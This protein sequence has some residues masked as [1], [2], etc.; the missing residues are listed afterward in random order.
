MPLKIVTSDPGGRGGTLAD[1]LAR[2]PAGLPLADALTLA[3]QI[4]AALEDRHRRGILHA[5]LQP[6]AI[7]VS[8]GGVTLLDVAGG[9]AAVDGAP[10]AYA[11]PEQVR[12][13]TPDR[14]TD[15]W[16]FGC[17][18]FEML[19]G[20]P[21]FGSD[22]RTAALAAIVERHPDWS[23]LP[24]NAPTRI[25]HLLQHCL[26]K[27]PNQRLHDIADARIEIDATRR[28]DTDALER[29]IGPRRRLA[30]PVAWIAIGL[31][32]AA[33][34]GLLWNWRRATQP[35]T[36]T[37]AASGRPLRA[38]LEL[39]PGT[40][41]AI[42]RG[43][44]LALSPDGSRLVYVA[45]SHGTVQLHLRLLD[46]GESTP[47]AGTEG[48]ADPFFSPDGNWIGFF[49]AEK[50][51]KVSAGGGVPVTVA[52][53]PTQRGQ[54][55]GID[56]TIVLA[57]RDNT[58]L[59]RVSANGG[60]LEPLTTLA[61]GDVSHR[62]PHV[63][64]GIRAVLYTIWSGAWEPARI[65]V[66]SL[67]G[68][69]RRIL[70]TGAGFARFVGGARADRGH[71]IYAQ[72]EGLMAAAFD[73]AKLEFT[74]AP[75]VVADSVL[76]NFSGGAQFTVAQ[77]GVLAYVAAPDETAERDLVWV[78]RDGKTSPAIKLRG[79]GRWYDLSPDGTRV[80]RYKTEGATRD[81][82]ANDLGTD[83]ATRLSVRA[84]SSSA[85]TAARL[86]VI[87]SA[88]GTRVT[89]AAGQPL[90]VF[91][92]PSDGSGREERLTRSGNTQWPGSWSPDGRT[93]AYVENDPL[94]GSDIWVLT[95]TEPGKPGAV[96]PFLSTPF[97]ESAP[98]ISPDGRWIAYQSNE[99]GR[100]EIYVQPF[101]DGGR[102]WQVSSDHGVYPRWSPRGDALFYRS[103]AD[104]SGLTEVPV[105]TQ[106]EFQ[107]GTA[108]L[109]FTRR[110]M[111]SIFEV[112]PDA[113]RFLMMPVATQG[114]MTRINVIVNAIR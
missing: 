54:T 42:G 28:T 75:V 95:Q 48:A 100:Y 31:L 49:A 12:G 107:P 43:S 84:D 33:N 25:V 109:M 59:W 87:W 72:P 71:L 19:G 82:W 110:G 63:L 66:Q 56:N 81:V 69:P 7:A 27:D 22:N 29:A 18:L 15:I 53:V 17:V 62:W 97:N 50:L 58:G 103:A 20:T 73:L 32:V 34:A 64:P 1:I 65:A 93:L 88:D 113:G 61:E 102:R 46:R 57:P 36:S 8:D 4:A 23:R 101:P 78:T 89:Y 79:L 38:F 44:S 10:A 24:T 21:A 108:R 37:S 51:M 30:S 77:T 45:E 41:L 40:A 67:D 85:G 5:G 14:R 9:D 114:P 60:T 112:S 26:Q 76:T 13:K 99:S 68:G 52:A 106:P 94:S 96:R 47:I 92:A 70:A 91:A 11:S 111:E 3:S 83:G 6:A 35:A 98:M 39:P 16:A 90:N 104:R 2:A 55:W 105:T 74:G 80:L 86:N